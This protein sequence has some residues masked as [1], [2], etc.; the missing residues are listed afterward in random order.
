MFMLEDLLVRTGVIKFYVLFKICATTLEDTS[1]HKIRVIGQ[2]A[3]FDIIF[4]SIR[5]SS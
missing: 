4:I 2:S 3:V 5:I 1:C